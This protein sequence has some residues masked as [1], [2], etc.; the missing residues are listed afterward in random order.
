MNIL[1]VNAGSVTIK[2]KLFTDNEQVLLAGELDN[3]NGKYVSKL[4]KNNEKF[5]W[6]I[7]KNEF[8]N[9]A[10]LIKREVAAHAI[11]IIGFRVVHGADKFVAPTLLDEPTI[12]KLAEF[13]HLAP[14]HN[15]RTITL[16]NKFKEVFS[17]HPIYAVFDTAFFKDL[18]PKAYMY[19]LPY[20]YYTHYGVRKYGFHGIAHQ[21]IASEL[22]RLEPTA[23]KVITCQLGGGASITAINNCT[24]VDTSMG[25]TPQEGLMM[26]T[27]SGDV[28]DGAIKYIQD[29]TS[30]S[31]AQ[32]ETIGNKSSGLLGISGY[33]A[34][35]RTLLADSKSGNERAKL[36]IEMYVYRIQKYIGAYA[37]ALNGVDAIAISGGVGAGS[38]IIRA[39]IF[40]KLQFLG[41]AIDKDANDG[42]INVTEKLRISLDTSRPIWIIPGNEE[43]QIYRQL[44]TID[45]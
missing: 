30:F 43:L 25:F 33:T 45:E 29:K 5:I 1:I 36:A 41:F 14:L 18:A 2:Y 40:E 19:G 12:S 35:M 21:Y 22:R 13:S 38:D 31:D 11:D 6:D 17:K 26:A 44:L 32:M 23:L 16:I 20:E 37:A 4:L 8:D 7:T 27:R 9:A 34:D 42:K 24:A 10:M 3:E 28:D 15:P 39:K